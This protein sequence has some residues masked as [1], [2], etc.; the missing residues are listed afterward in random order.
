MNLLISCVIVHLFSSV[1]ADTKLWIGP[2][3]NFDNPRN[4]DH[5]QKP[6]SS[7]TI[8]FNGS[9]NLPIEF[10]VG[11]MKACEVILP[12][13]GE[14]IMPSNAIMSIG[15]EDGTSRC[16]GQDV[17]TMRNRSYWLDPKNWYSDQVNLATPDLERLPCTGDTVVF[18]H[19]LTYS[20]YIPN[21]VIHKLII[22]N[23]S[24][25]QDS[26][27]DFIWSDTGAKMFAL[28]PAL[29]AAMGFDTV[30]VIMLTSACE[31][32]GGCVC[33]QQTDPKVDNVCHVIRGECL[34]RMPCTKPIL[35]QGSCCPICG[36]QLLF[37]SSESF[38]MNQTRAKLRAVVAKFSA[39]VKPVDFHIS[40]TV[41]NKIQVVLVEHGEYEGYVEELANSILEMIKSDPNFHLTLLS[42]VLHAG[43]PYDPYGHSNTLGTLFITCVLSLCVLVA[44][45]IHYY[46]DGWAFLGVGRPQ[47]MASAFVFQRFD[48]EKKEAP[49]VYE[50]TPRPPTKSFDNPMYNVESA[51]VDG[52]ETPADMTGIQSFQEL[53]DKY[54]DEDESDTD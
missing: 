15:G 12:M 51:E 37:K 52:I 45:Y 29:D 23:Q 53:K 7:E 50:V 3:T 36:A 32:Q 41:Q 18:V 47:P 27:N 22:N 13:N 44:I 42:S 39:Q 30:P 31:V 33:S 19:G 17:Y 24:F 9:Y 34:P 35:P 38:N 2:S 1:Y 49:M 8:V 10:P 20:L 40:R 11:K 26:L 43:F 16:S 48:N 28:D 46:H 4:W 21:V 5:R 6:S 25:F 54:E 14:I